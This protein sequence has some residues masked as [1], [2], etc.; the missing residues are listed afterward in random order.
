MVMLVYR[1]VIIHPESDPLGFTSRPFVVKN[2][3]HFFARL[4]SFLFVVAREAQLLMH[5]NYTIFSFQGVS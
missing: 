4:E 3:D 5:L 1:W 2:C